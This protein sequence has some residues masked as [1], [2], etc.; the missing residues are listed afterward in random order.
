MLGSVCIYMLACYV[1]PMSNWVMD[2]ANTTHSHTKC[3]CIISTYLEHTEYNPRIAHEHYV[4]LSPELF[5]NLGT[6]EKRTTITTL[7][8]YKNMKLRRMG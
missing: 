8:E 6:R 1:A 4:L 3:W 5:Y 2:F 7:T